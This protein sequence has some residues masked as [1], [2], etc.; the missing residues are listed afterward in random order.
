MTDINFQ[1]NLKLSQ[2]DDKSA[3][4]IILEIMDNIKNEKKVDFKELDGQIFLKIRKYQ[5]TSIDFSDHDM[6]NL[7]PPVVTITLEG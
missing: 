6:T 4:S 5:P 3:K 1:I 2:L 7:S